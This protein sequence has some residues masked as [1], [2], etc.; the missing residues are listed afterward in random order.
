MQFVHET[1]AARVVFGNGRAADVEAELALLGGR[2]LVISTQSVAREA[3]GAAVLAAL[4]ACAVASIDRVRQHVP[5]EDAASARR[6]SR[7]C[8]AD[9]ILAIGGGSAVGLA[10]AI[11]MT[12][13][14][15]I[16]AIPTTY[17]GSEMTPV[18]GLP[19]RGTKTTGRDPKVA[20]RTVIY[21][22]ALTL[23]LSAQTTAASGLNAIAH[24][25]DALWAPSRTPLT[26]VMAER[27]IAVLA[28]SLPAAVADGH[29]LN[30]RQ[31]ALLGAWLAAATFAAAGSS[32]HH[33]ICHFLG[34]RFNLPHAQTHAIVLPW[35]TMLAARHLPQAGAVVARAL[36]RDEP[37]H[38]LRRLA[39]ELGAPTS[40]SEIG[41]REPD[42]RMAAD[43]IELAALSTPFKITRDELRELLVGATIGSTDDVPQGRRT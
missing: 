27:A 16:V 23:S 34:G 3:A 30:A 18:W 24:S 8:N 2:P 42:A 11:A 43:E 14:L 4:T 6:L 29:D 13:G 7:A 9:S 40:L 17:A 15:P 37:A 36:G 39:S 41:L 1:L 22:P 19:E 21:D 26:D 28:Q 10:K 33:K 31:D 38:A 12:D 20:P 32:L 35:A 25:V 5:V